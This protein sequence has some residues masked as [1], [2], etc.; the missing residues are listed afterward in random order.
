MTHQNRKNSQFYQTTMPPI[1]RLRNRKAELEKRPAH[2]SKRQNLK[3][4]TR[5]ANLLCL[6]FNQGG[7]NERKV[8]LWT[9][10]DGYKAFAHT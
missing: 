7:R 10:A 4:T 8:V 1:L 9:S 6:F 5:Y 2:T 3:E